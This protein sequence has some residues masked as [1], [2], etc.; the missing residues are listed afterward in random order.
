VRVRAVWIW[1]AAVLAWAATGAVAPAAQAAFGVEAK[2]FEA[3]TCE[4]ESCT[5]ASVEKN[6]G[7]AYTQAAGHP[8][9]GITGFKLN[10]SGEDPEGTLKRARVDIPS[11]LAANPQALEKC[12]IA[13]FE[14]GDCGVNHPGSRVGTNKLTAYVEALGLTIKNEAPVYDLEQPAGLPL[15]FGIEVSSPPLLDEHIFLEGHVSWN[16]DYHEYFEINNITKEIEV[17]V[18]PPV[19]VKTRVA[20]LKSELI[21]NGRAGKGDFLTLPSECSSTTTSYLEV[22]SWEGQVSKTSTHTPVG[23]EGCGKVPFAPLAEVHPETAQSDEPDGVSTEVKVPQDSSP[24]AIN[25]ADIDDAHLVLP[26]GL[27]LNPAAASGLVACTE[28]QAGLAEAQP[29]VRST[30]PVTCPAGSKVGSLTIETDLPPGSLTG[31]IYLASPHGGAI[32]GPPYTIYMDAESPY[33]VSVRLAGAVEPDLSTGRLGVTFSHNPQLPFSDLIAEFDGGALA[34][35]ANPLSCAVQQTQALF[36]TYA[37]VT[38]TALSSTPFASSGCPTPLPFALSQSTTRTSPDAGAYTSFT[39]NLARADGQQYLS[40]VQTTLPPGLVGAI[41][42]V[43]L[44]GEPQANTGTC[45]S[46]SEIG[47]VAVSAGAGPTPYALTGRAFLTGP[48][49]GAPYGLSIAVP[50]VAGGPPATPTFDLGTVVV[51]AQVGVDQYTGRVIVSGAVPTIVQGIPLRLRS[52]AVTVNRPN[53]LFNPSSC[54]ALATESTLTGFTPG[55]SGT[56]TQNISTPFQVGEC[57][58]LPFTPKLTASAGAKT[59]KVNGASLQV[60]LTQGAGTQP[61]GL[62]QANIREVLTALPKQ[63]P[64]RLTTLA[65]ACPAATFEVAD[66]PGACSPQARVGEATASTPVLPGKLTGPAYLVSH[67]GEA[68]PDLDVILRGDGVTVVLVGHTHISSAGITTTNFETLPDVPVSSFTLDLPVGPHSA[69][70]ANG[71][72]CTAKNLT[73]PTTIVA[74]SGA[75][76]TQQTKIAVSGCPVEILRHRVS[77][78]RLLLTV[79]TPSA[80]RLTVRSADLSPLTRRL[81]TG[82]RRTIAIPLA[83]AARAR[84]RVL[85]RRKRLRIAVR[86]RFVP[87]SGHNVSTASTKVTLKF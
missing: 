58:K 13:E 75:K 81:R 82:G 85:H 21:F 61:A 14:K 43:P 49:D 6:H 5:Y 60:T 69:L 72:I 46:A 76:L 15:D 62:G 64:S 87:N 39:F 78:G 59:S 7:E 80:G 53:F 47:T 9:F 63:L 73:M 27:T 68:F 41:P 65:K 67:G 79:W 45:P 32:T 54:G 3:G 66:P 56:A 74:Q 20:V 24:E 17:E 33:G 19:K 2:N 1:L 28:A 35:L 44:C 12:P 86:A 51:R 31:N 23:V 50:A 10:A 83:R 37:S 70:T 18:L 29:G 25:T 84:S 42:S 26:E 48:Y 71:N 77:K 4:V 30:A 40:Q 8:P 36:T 34:P 38:G 22:E 52:I 16:T 57:G 55:V 11:G